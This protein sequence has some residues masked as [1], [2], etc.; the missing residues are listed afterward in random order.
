MTF[1][2]F[3]CVIC[4]LAFCVNGYINGTGHTR[5]TMMLNVVS[6][7]FV[8]LPLVWF[9]ST[10]A[11]V[12]LYHIGIALPVASVVQLAIGVAFLLFSRSERQQ[13]EK[14]RGAH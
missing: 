9:I 8:R 3:D 2:K 6:S 12:T 10:R 7:F 5:Y 13:R 14:L 1:Y 11:G 4:T